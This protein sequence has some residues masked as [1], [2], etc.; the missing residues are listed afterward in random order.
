MELT[1][2]QKVAKL[3]N[4]EKAGKLYLDEAAALRK[5]LGIEGDGGGGDMTATVEK[6]DQNAALWDKMTPAEKM[7][8]YSND[9]ERWNAIKDAYEAEGIRK[10]FHKRSVP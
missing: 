7:E 6:R 10:L 4:L 5:E 1:K 3:G 8:L 9:R 2:E